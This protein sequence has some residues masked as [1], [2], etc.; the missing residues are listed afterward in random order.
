[1]G[2]KR[3]TISSV[4]D[5]DRDILLQIIGDIPDKRSTLFIDQ[6]LYCIGLVT[7]L[8][9]IIDSYR[10][11]IIEEYQSLINSYDTQLMGIISAYDE[12][13][14]KQGTNEALNKIARDIKQFYDKHC[15]PLYGSTQSDRLVFFYAFIKSNI[16]EEKTGSEE[17]QKLKQEYR[18]AIDNITTKSNN[19]DKL[20]E[21]L[22]NKG[23][24]KN[25]SDYA[26]V[27]GSK[28]NGHKENSNLWLGFGIGSIALFILFLTLS[29]VFEWFPS[30]S[31]ENSRYIYGNLFNKAMIV[32]ICIF[33]I[34][35]CLK[36][37][38]IQR[39]LQTVNQ[40]RADT[41]NSYD[42]YK[43]SMSSNVSEDTKDELLGHI[44]KTIY[45]HQ[46]TG[47]ISEKNQ[48]VNSGMFELTKNIVGNNPTK[49]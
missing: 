34:T 39:H 36:Q 13:V 48:T 15:S 16:N 8:L 29:T 19:A 22:K 40:H 18:T 37:F 6:Y 49:A 9:N 44:A 21:S 41:L 28:A 17:L 3:A 2:Y 35:F 7:E 26:Q 31:E 30:Y 42:L 1:M 38:S 14:K 47:F 5:I 43:V 27:Y 11:S 32:A 20:Y 12:T 25:I 10:D 24:E 23:K 46:P 45:D 4:K 33:S